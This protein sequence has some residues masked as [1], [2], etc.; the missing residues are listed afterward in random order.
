MKKILLI[1]LLAFGTFS[2]TFA[3]SLKIIKTGDNNILN[4]STL[5]IY[6]DTGTEMISTLWIINTTADS[7]KVDA[8]RDS[9]SWLVGS[10]NEIC[11][12]GTCYSFSTSISPNTEDIGPGDTAKLASQFNGDYFPNSSTG[13]S[14]FRYSFYNPFSRADSSW[15]I[16][17]YV[18]VVTGIASLSGSAISISAPY[19]NPADNSASFNYKLASSVSAANLKIFN[20]I[21][22]CIQTL[23]LNISK[24]K[25]TLNVQTIPS[26]IYIC[27][28]EADGCQPVYQ[29]LVVSH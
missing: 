19:P 27:E 6:G 12:A 1:S 15:V 23:P 16:V 28:I 7:M 9:I 2:M 24:Y 26:G 10:E 18:S 4:D 17:K 8:R 3:Q 14:T 25:T 22:E 5:T 20:L 11:W 21:G 13:T 29:K